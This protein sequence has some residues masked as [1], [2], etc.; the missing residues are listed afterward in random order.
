MLYFRLN[1]FQLLV[2]VNTAIVLV[3]DLI[4]VNS[5]GSSKP[6]KCCLFDISSLAV[7]FILRF[8][9]LKL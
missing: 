8:L 1:S 2:K 4:A 5:K 9:L 3:R 7:N 6:K